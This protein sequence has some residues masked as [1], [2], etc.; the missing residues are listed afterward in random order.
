MKTVLHPDDSIIA[1]KMVITSSL[2]ENIAYGAMKTGI[3]QCFSKPVEPVM[4]KH[5]ISEQIAN[6]VIQKIERTKI[7]ACCVRWETSNQVFKYS[8]DAGQ[9]VQGDHFDETREKMRTVLKA[10]II[11][12]I[13]NF[14]GITNV[15]IVNY[16]LETN[17]SLSPDIEANEDILKIV[18]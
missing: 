11:E 7:R 18:E 5:I 12:D 10:N 15:Q 16:L 9:L 1:L 8:L 13:K 4:I 17:E 3:N 2:S 6:P 14:E